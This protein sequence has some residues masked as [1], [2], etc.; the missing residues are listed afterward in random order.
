MSPLSSMPYR[1]HT[2][3][4]CSAAVWYSLACGTSFHGPLFGQMPK[5]ISAYNIQVRDHVVSAKLTNGEWW[6]F[7]FRTLCACCLLGNAILQS[8]IVGETVLLC[9]CGFFYT[10]HRTLNVCFFV[11]LFWID[12]PVVIKSAL[13]AWKYNISEFCQLLI[14]VLSCSSF[15]RLYFW[16]WEPVFKTLVACSLHPSPGL[17]RFHFICYWTLRTDSSWRP[18]VF[19][20][21]WDRNI[22]ANYYTVVASNSLSLCV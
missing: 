6:F 11:C 9:V 22:S 16:L 7:L 14:K 15:L 12:W 18:Q 17:W 1:G 10:L 13:T 4:K 5:S 8:C 19:F 20:E 2:G 21:I 3:R